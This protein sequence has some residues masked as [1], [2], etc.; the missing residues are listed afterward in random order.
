MGSPVGLNR[1]KPEALGP[2]DRNAEGEETPGRSLRREPEHGLR[3]HA[4]KWVEAYKGM[5][6]SFITLLTGT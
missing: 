4:L 2:D 6:V 5:K 1:C 3:E